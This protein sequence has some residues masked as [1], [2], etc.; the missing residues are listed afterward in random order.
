MCLFLKIRP[1]S[2]LSGRLESTPLEATNVSGVYGTLGVSSGGAPGSRWG[3]ST[4]TDGSGNLWMFGGQ[5]YDSSTLDFSLLNDIW[6]WIPGARDPNGAGTFTGE[7]I[8]QGG[9]SVGN[10]LTVAN[11]PG[12]RWAAATFADS[13]GNVWLFGGQGVD[14]AGNTGLLSDLWKYNTA[15]K[16]WTLVSGSTLGNKNG[17]YGT[18]GTPAAGNFPGGRQHGVLWVDASGKVWLF[19]GFGFDSAGTGSPLG[20]LLNDLWEFSGGQWTWV[21]GN[22]LANQTGTYGTQTLP[23]AANV[24]GSRWGSV[25]WTDASSN[26]WFFGGWGYGSVNTHPTGFLDDI[27]EYQHSTGQ[28]IWWKGAT[29]TNQNGQYLTNGIPFVNNVAG[30]RRGSSLFFAP[31][32]GQDPNFY[33]WIFGGEGFDSS[34]GAAPGYLNDLW[35]YLP[36]P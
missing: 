32:T 5:G 33:V 25:A 9:S 28:W 7:W 29:D 14:S 17:V 24:P 18:Q 26:L 1:S 3:S 4:W 8:W 2:L 35:T 15:L 16:T 36:F 21:S 19:G 10:Q 11:A 31:P 13:V 22:D 34:Q 23:G 27:W 20:A 12:G 6:E 30:A